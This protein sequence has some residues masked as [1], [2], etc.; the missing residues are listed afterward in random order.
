MRITTTLFSALALAACGGN[1]NPPKEALMAPA[2]L[3]T[4]TARPSID[5]AL[6]AKVET[7]TFAM[8]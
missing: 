5:L 1:S 2:A 6:P 3:T 8:G 4:G 7:A